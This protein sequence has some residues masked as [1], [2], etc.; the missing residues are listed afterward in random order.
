MET[1]T[2][3][4]IVRHKVRDF[5]ARKKAF[6]GHASAQRAAGLTNP[7]VY[8]STDD[9]NETVIEFDMRDIVAAKK[10]ATS[11]DLKSTMAPA[12]VF[13]QPTMHFSKTQLEPILNAPRTQIEA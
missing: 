13:D 7:H 4:L 6:D 5:A 8:R 9:R 1:I 3:R 2:G 12:G 10:F 11:A